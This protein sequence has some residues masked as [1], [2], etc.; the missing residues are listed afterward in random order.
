[1]ISHFQEVGKGKEKTQGSIFQNEKE[2]IYIEG[3]N[4]R[5]VFGREKDKSFPLSSRSTKN[6]PINKSSC[7]E[8]KKYSSHSDLGYAT[9]HAPK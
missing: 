6:D 3:V 7:S 8:A 1:M 5:E 4:E 9:K 2:V